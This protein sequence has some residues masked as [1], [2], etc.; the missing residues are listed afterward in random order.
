VEF[1]RLWLALAPHLAD[2]ATIELQGEDLTRWRIR[3]SGGRVFEEFPKEIIWDLE[4]EI[5][6]ESLKE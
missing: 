4:R 2:E 3:W 5:T 1:R 6:L